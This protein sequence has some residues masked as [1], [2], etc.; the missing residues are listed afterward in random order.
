MLKKEKEIEKTISNLTIPVLKIR[1][2]LY[3]GLFGKKK[4]LR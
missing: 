3:V 4:N 2:N 1:P